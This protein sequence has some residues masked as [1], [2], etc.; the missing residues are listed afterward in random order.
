MIFHTFL[1]S[2]D[3]GSHLENREVRKKSGKSQGKVREIHEKLSKSGKND[4]VLANDL[5][6]V[7]VPHFF[8]IFCQRIRLMSVTFCY[9][10]DKLESGKNVLIQEKVM[11][12]SGKMKT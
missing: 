6:N 11:E 2:L 10:T 9:T 12:K 8:C 7:D 5:E 1:N 3:Q 4:I